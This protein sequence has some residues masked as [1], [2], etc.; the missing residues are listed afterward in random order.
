[1]LYKYKAYSFSYIR[2]RQAL[3]PQ[4]KCTQRVRKR[5]EERN[6]YVLGSQ[7]PFILNILFEFPQPSCE[8]TTVEPIVSQIIQSVFSR[9]KMC[10]LVYLGTL[11]TA[12]S[13]TH[14]GTL[15][16]WMLPTE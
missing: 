2:K 7:L 12:Q 5:E 16:P 13:S 9:D 15:L 10:P 8:V 4:V 14:T 1:M 3:I 11:P 6:E